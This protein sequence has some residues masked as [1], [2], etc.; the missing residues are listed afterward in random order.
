[1][2]LTAYVWMESKYVSG[3]VIPSNSDSK[4]YV[5]LF[6]FIHLYGHL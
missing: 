2:E 3:I 1:M 6:E 4:A 5:D